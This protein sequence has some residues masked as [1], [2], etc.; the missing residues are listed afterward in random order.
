MKTYVKPIM[1]SEMFVANEYCSPCSSTTPVACLNMNQA[2]FVFKDVNGNGTYEKNIDKILFSSQGQG[3]GGI[4]HHSSLSMQDCGTDG[5]AEAKNHIISETELANSDLRVFVYYS[6]N[7][8]VPAIMD[9]NGTDG[10]YFS[11]SP[12]FI[13]L[14]VANHS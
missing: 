13:S 5:D 6:S 8:I 9:Y 3:G 11:D 7:N 12:H 14:K 4:G 2:Q 10:K 1:E